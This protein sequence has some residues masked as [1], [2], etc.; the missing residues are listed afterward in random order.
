MNLQDFN[1]CD[2][3]DEQFLNLINNISQNLEQNIDLIDDDETFQFFSK[4]NNINTHINSVKKRARLLKIGIIGAVKAGKSSFLNALIFNGEQILPKAPT[5]MTAALTKIMYSEIPQAKIVFYKSYDWKNIENQALKYKNELKRAIAEEE[6]K[7]K[8]IKNLGPYEKVVV[9]KKI[10]ENRVRNKIGSNIVASYELISM[11][12]ANN[13]QPEIYLDKEEIIQ[14]E[15]NESDRKYIDKL[16]DYV[17]A[18]GKYT[19]LVN[20][21]ELSISNKLLKGFEIIDTPGLN[22]P[23]QSR[24][25]ATK[26][27]LAACDVVLL[28]SPVG[29][30]LTYND[31]ALLTKKFTEESIPY[32]YIIGSQ[33]DN[34]VLQYNR[35]EKSFQKAYSQSV[36]IYRNQAKNELENVSHNISSPFIDQLKKSLPPEFVSSM[37][38]NIAKKLELG[39]ELNEEEKHIKEQYQKRFI[40]FNKVIEGIDDYYD[41]A[42]INGVKERVYEE[43]KKN[44]EVIIDKKIKEF[45]SSQAV[46]LLSRLEKINIISKMNLDNLQNGDF[47]ELEKKLN[48]LNS[49]LDSMRYDIANLFERQA[50]DSNRI[51]QDIKIKIGDDIDK[52][53]DFKIRKETETKFRKEGGFFG[54]FQKSV[55]YSVEH[56]VADAS[57]V[58]KNV[59]KFGISG[60]KKI[61]EELRRLIDI[62]A[63][64]DNV[65]KTVIKAFDLSNTEFHPNEILIP[66]DTLCSKITIHDVSIDF[67]AQVE[68]EVYDVFPDGRVRD[69]DI[70]RLN[71]LQEKENRYILNLLINALDKTQLDIQKSM[72]LEASSFVDKI[73]EKMSKNIENT[74]KQLKNREENIKKYENLI[75]NINKY[76]IEISEYKE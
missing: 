11:V 38:F 30:F 19:P 25:E 28:V 4:V 18:T 41:F 16:Y 59:L 12:K 32:A 55:Q 2:K 68:K 6:N 44:K 62:E 66:L 53:S 71:V 23:I 5:P 60:Q 58:L 52:Y 65:K 57:E 10:I 36:K 22:D 15:K 42:N 69:S 50:I 14:G 72:Q 74:K 75:A 67:M 20:Y 47:N 76:K 48:I 54:F 56:S 70:H 8:N 9:D 45:T 1:V 7:Y 63:L 39:E 13:I 46:D 37:M 26:R 43:I 3:K 34:G 17:G 49:R 35:N 64:K 73:I 51:I 33:L 24:S 27:Y 61:N 40:D 21:I 31:M 29:Q